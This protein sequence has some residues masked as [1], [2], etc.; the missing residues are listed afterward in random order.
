MRN[1]SFQ[2]YLAHVDNLTVSQL[3]TLL[4]RL[5]MQTSQEAVR[6][7][8]EKHI[9]NDPKCPHCQSKHIQR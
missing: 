8:I 6:C 2:S 7:E 5:T 3:E 1:K 4:E 9:G